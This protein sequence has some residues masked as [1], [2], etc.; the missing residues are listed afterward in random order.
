MQKLSPFKGKNGNRG[1]SQWADGNVH[2]S[3]GGTLNLSALKGVTQQVWA[4][5]YAWPTVHRSY[6]TVISV[7]GQKFPTESLGY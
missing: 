1:C 7:D 5:A 2:F 6:Y 3:S 4:M